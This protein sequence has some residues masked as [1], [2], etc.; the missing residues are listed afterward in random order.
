ML[1]IATIALASGAAAAAGLV[2]T[3]PFD[4]SECCSSESLASTSAGDA[5]PV[6]A[7]HGH[8]GPGD[9]EG[10]VLYVEARDATVWGGACHVSAQAASGGSRAACAWAFEDARVVLAVEGSHNLQGHEVFNSGEAPEVRVAAWVDAPDDAA[11]EAALER[12]LRS[13]QGLPAPSSVERA[14]VAVSAAEGGFEVSVEGVLRLSGEDVPDGACCTMPESRWYAPL[15][16]VDSSVV[17]F[18][19]QCRFEGGGGLGAWSYEG[20]NSVF[21]ARAPAGADGGCCAASAPSADA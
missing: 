5:M 11:A 12:A 15:A 20:E 19:G 1:K 9:A 21:V 14:A 16:G 18:A 17:G 8:A 7:G 2:G 13:A 10:A 6:D 4:C 3:N